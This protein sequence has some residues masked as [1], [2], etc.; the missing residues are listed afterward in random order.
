MSNFG[1]RITKVQP[2]Y[3]VYVTILYSGQLYGSRLVCSIATETLQDQLRDF[4]CF[5]DTTTRYDNYFAEM[6]LSS[7]QNSESTEPIIPTRRESY[8]SGSL[9]PSR[10][11]TPRKKKV[12]P[13]SKTVLR[14]GSFL[15]RLYSI[16]WVLQIRDSSFFDKIGQIREF[17]EFPY[18][19]FSRSYVK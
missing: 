17:L 7:Q 15:Y 11:G 18:L 19:P 4:G 5:K 14:S 2:L 8:E 13:E 1:N 12:D 9:I 3:F 6:K 16:Q 10:H